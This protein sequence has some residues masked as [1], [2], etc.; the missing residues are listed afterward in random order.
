MRAALAALA[1]AACTLDPG[2]PAGALSPRKEVA[3][4]WLQQAELADAGPEVE[5]SAV[6][7]APICDVDVGVRWWSQ[8]LERGPV[9]RD[10]QPREATRDGKTWT[11]TA[12]QPWLP[13]TTRNVYVEVGLLD[14]A[15]ERYEM[16]VAQN[17][18]LVQLK[19][20]RM[21]TFWF[22]SMEFAYVAVEVRGDGSYLVDPKSDAEVWLG[23]PPP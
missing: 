11:V 19:C 10:G 1:L 3:L 14:Q 6:V 20:R 21:P 4:H 7:R 12:A 15:A 18:V 23:P 5:H 17:F 13:N 22:Q 8:P 9:S 16:L 2:T